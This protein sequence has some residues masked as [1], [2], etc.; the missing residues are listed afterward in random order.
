M[1]PNDILTLY[2]A[3]TSTKGGKR[4]PV[5]IVKTTSDTVFLYRITSKYK[6]KSSKIKNVYYPIGKWREA[7]LKKESYIDIGTLIEVEYSLLSNT[8]KIGT[9]IETDQNGLAEFIQKKS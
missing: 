1:N 8:K 9:L 4:R 3:Y 2:V 7:G 6:N 5:L